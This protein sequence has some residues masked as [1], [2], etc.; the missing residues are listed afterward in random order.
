MTTEATIDTRGFVERHGLWSDEQWKA[1]DE[2]R[3]RIQE[4]NLETVRMSWPDQHGLLRGKFLSRRAFLSA[5][6]NGIEI[7]MAPFFFDTAN[8]IVYNPFIAGGGFGMPELSGS[9][10]VIMV[11][12][13]TTFRVL[14]WA[15]STGWCLSDLYFRTGAEFPF[16]PRNIYRRALQKL[17]EAGY[18]YVAGLEV[19]WYL[20]R[21]VDPALEP[22]QLGKGPGYPADPPHVM[23]LAHGYNYLLEA[24]LDEVDD[25]LSTIRSHLAALD[26]PIRTTDDEWA[27]SQI[28]S[29]FDPLV[30]MEAADGMTLFRSAVKQIARRLG[31]HATFMCQPAIPGFYASGWH[32]HQSLRD[33]STGQN[34]FTAQDTAIS[35][36]G[37]FFA[38]GLLDHARA[39]S[40]FTTQTVNGYKRRRPFSLAPDRAAWGIDN[41]AAMARVVGG[42]G[43][44]GT[45][46]ENRVGEP[47]ANPYLYMASQVVS[48][49]DGIRRSLDPGDPSDEPY[50]ADVPILPKTLAE[51][52]EVLE[53]D[54][55]FRNEF[56]ANFVDYIITMKRSELNRYL[57]AIGGADKLPEVAMTTTEW[58]QREYFE[59]F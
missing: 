14:P 24:H 40:V 39:A 38:G 3:R 8:A 54:A 36:V 52:L 31:Y 25:I 17:A 4:L 43:D 28:E 18:D 41:R 11:P 1:A 6:D 10:N 48:G 26:L 2:L 12:D 59:L 16:A 7:T 9:P 56:G 58:E 53:G 57:E 42:P 29:T 35:T 55:F 34:A 45:R 51:A 32:L 33:R 15:K 30:G 5:L 47:A 19:E 21:L 50:M 44:P 37:R 27:P 20:T 46:I 13:P 49:L 22:S 23:P